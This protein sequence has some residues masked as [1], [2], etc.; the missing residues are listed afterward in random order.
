MTDHDSTDHDDSFLLD[1]EPLEAF[2]AREGL[3]QLSASLTVAVSARSERARVLASL[4][5]YQ[6]F[7]RFEA[8][9]AQILG[10]SNVQAAAALS[11]ID[12]ERAWRTLA[13][14]IS[15]LPLA[16]A[17]ERGFAVSGFLRVA[18]GTVFPRHEHL[19]EELTYVLQGAFED[20]S[21]GCRFGPGEP[22]RMP[23]GSR[24]GFSVPAQ[25]PHLVGLVTIRNGFQLL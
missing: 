12:D 13:L 16:A 6:R 15:L 20:D 1:L 19:G 7:A 4:H 3:W 10:V 24:H 14:G 22:A 9:V 11:Q 21:N 2:T 5:P 23:M 17:E 25:G 18:A 8:A